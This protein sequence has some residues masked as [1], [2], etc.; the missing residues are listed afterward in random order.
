MTHAASLPDSG[1]KFDSFLHATIGDDRNGMRLSVLSALAR[2]DLDPWHEAASL[3]SLAG[4][5]AIE[6]LTHMISALPDEPSAH[7]DSASIAAR[8]VTLLPSGAG[9]T[10]ALSGPSPA[11]DPY[12]AL[13][14][15][16][17][18]VLFVAFMLSAQWFATNHQAP[19]S[20]NIASPP[21]ATA[22]ALRPPGVG[23]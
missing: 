17:V 10:R 7:R 15:I 21:Q 6:R 8:L 19:A 9:A 18:N 12:S 14:M 13:R 4:P 11:S 3:A 23:Q 5:S 1:S 16:L 20:G 22:S 2:L